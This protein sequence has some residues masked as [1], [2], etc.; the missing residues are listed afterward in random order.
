MP[1]NARRV[2]AGVGATGS[3]QISV[4]DATSVNPDQ[5]LPCFRPGQLDL[6]YHQGMAKRLEDCGSNLHERHLRDRLNGKL[7]AYHVELPAKLRRV[8]RRW[9]QRLD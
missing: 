6:L 2:T 1:Q 9:S 5:R 8:L 7:E 4:T 3:V